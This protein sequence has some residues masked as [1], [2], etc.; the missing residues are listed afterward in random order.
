MVSCYNYRARNGADLAQV[1][2]KKAA[3]ET[4]AWVCFLGN[5]LNC[6]AVPAAYK[7]C[8]VLD[9]CNHVMMEVYPE[10]ILYEE[11]DHVLGSSAVG[12]SMT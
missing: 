6:D 1:P 11:D 5:R 8:F 12:L 9:H 7:S 2:D 10:W 4:T 3:Y